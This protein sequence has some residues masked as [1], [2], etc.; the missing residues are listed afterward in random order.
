MS[1]HS[2]AA[3]GL[4][5]LLAFAALPAA[6]AGGNASIRFSGRLHYDTA[7][8]DND[9]RGAPEQQGD[10]LRAA[11][12]AASGKLHGFDYKVEG[13]FAPHK[14]VA[15]D[16]YI[17]RRF[18]SNTVTLG[19]F[20]QYFTLDDRTST[21]HIPTI[22]RSWLAQA[23]APGYRLGLGMNGNGGDAFWSGS[24]YSLESIDAWKVKGRGAGVRAGYAPW[25][26]PGHVLHLGA[27]VARE[28]QDT[29][30]AGNAAAL[31]VQP[32][33]AG[34]FADNSRLSL[35]DFRAGRDV[36]V[37]KFGVEA[38]GV[39]GAWSWQAEYGGAHYDDGA[40]TA[41]VRAGYVQGSWLLTGEA[42][43][44]DAKAGRFV[45]IKPTDRTGALELVARY[46][47]I[48][49]EQ[50][51]LVRRDL[52]AEAWTVGVNW[53]AA[54][55]ARVMVDMTDS[56]RRNALTHSTLDHTRVLAG[57]LQLDF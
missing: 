36:T 14:P 46:D 5:A 31:R 16:A 43:S 51:P 34:Y 8:F 25:H 54:S 4:V 12:L 57:R 35:V 19:Q 50:R 24:V 7:F 20:K 38:A 18:G 1:T 21:N 41:D 10:D 40:Q 30:G 56:H 44:Y 23:L 6:H 49:G 15:R 17:A 2:H 27:S 47:H 45:Q 33:I 39:Q 3:R 29:P 9:G 26:A 28:Q 55:H 13:D 37:T 11:W 53:Y 52:S 22:E 48:D 32:R 42:R